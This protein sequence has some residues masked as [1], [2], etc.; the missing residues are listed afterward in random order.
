MAGWSWHLQDSWGRWK[1][2]KLPILALGHTT[3]LGEPDAKAHCSAGFQWPSK[4]TRCYTP[5]ATYQ[6]TPFLTCRCIVRLSES[7]F[8]TFSYTFEGNLIGLSYISEA[9]LFGYLILILCLPIITDIGSRSFPWKF[10]LIQLIYVTPL[11]VCLVKWSIRISYVDICED[12]HN[13]EPIFPLSTAPR[14]PSCNGVAIRDIVRLGNLN[15]NGGRPFFCCWSGHS[16]VFITWDD[17]RD[18]SVERPNS[19][20]ATACRRNQKLT[21]QP[22]AWYACALNYYGFRAQ[23]EIGPDTAELES[24]PLV[25]L[26]YIREHKTFYL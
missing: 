9:L 3:R 18:I 10:A 11:P 8:E 15:G 19:F 21:P 20:C 25:L 16:S 4:V 17:G 13:N 23:I 5:R 14:C 24:E 6:E 22:E 1:T 26:S 12:S 7:A 2:A